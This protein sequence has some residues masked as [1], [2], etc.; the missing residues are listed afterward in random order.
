MLY[1]ICMKSA[2]FKGNGLLSVE[3]QPM[4]VLNSTNNV[5]IK[6]ISC[7]ICGTDLNILSV[8]PMHKASENIIIGHEAVGIVT[9]VLQPLKNISVGDR[10]VIAPRILCGSCQYCRRGLENQCT[11]YT[12]VGT[13]RNGAFASFIAIPDSAVFKISEN[14]SNDDAVFFEPL[15]C[16]VGSV[17]K[18]PFV[19]GN[20][21][22]VI[23]AG[24]MGVLFA[25]LYRAMG[26]GD[27]IMID[28]SE[29]RLDFCK[30]LGLHTTYNMKDISTDEAHKK[31]QNIQADITVDAVGDQ[32]ESCIHTLRRGGSGILFGL[33]PHKNS[34]INQYTITRNDITLYGSFVGLIHLSI[35]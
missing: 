10:V 22:A 34:R 28:I 21:V 35:L 6:V 31:L 19:I 20:T 24:P 17:S 18:V 13:T 15:S 12:T 8:P 26:A 33:K 7:G 3:D 11:N 25:L 1:N 30:K 9:E 14:V 27:I 2:V 29:S 16:V 4:P 5:L 32:I 23:G